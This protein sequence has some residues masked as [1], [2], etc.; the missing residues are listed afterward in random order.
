[1]PAFHLFAAGIA[2][3]FVTELVAPHAGAA[4]SG[5]P[6][7]VLHVDNF[8]GGIS[9]GV[10]FSLDPEVLSAGPIPSE[11]RAAAKRR[12]AQCADE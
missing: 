7:W 12:Q 11:C 8:P 3:T 6:R 9:N 1:M 4:Q 10:R 2:L 5:K